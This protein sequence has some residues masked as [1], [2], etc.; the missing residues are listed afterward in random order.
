MLVRTPSSIGEVPTWIFDPK[1]EPKNNTELDKDPFTNLSDKEFNSI[2]RGLKRIE[3]DFKKTFTPSERRV[4]FKCVEQAYKEIGAG[5]LELESKHTRRDFLAFAVKTTGGV[6]A[7][8]IVGGGVGAIGGRC[9]MDSK[10]HVD[11][12]DGFMAFSAFMG[13]MIGGA[14][15]SGSANIDNKLHQDESLR[16]LRDSLGLAILAH[17]KPRTIQPS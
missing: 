9:L 4:L 13:A 10:E 12:L 2:E 8:S 15:A 14:L 17:M 1:T 3:P 5:T 16:L 6:V 7:G 11:Q